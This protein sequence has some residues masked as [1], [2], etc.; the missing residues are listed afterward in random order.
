MSMSENSPV[1]H[2]PMAKQLIEF[3]DSSHDDPG[4]RRWLTDP[5]GLT[6]Y[7]RSSLRPLGPPSEGG[8]RTFIQGVELKTPTDVDCL[9]IADINHPYSTDPV[10]MT[11]F[12]DFIETVYRLKLWDVVCLDNIGDKRI[13]DWCTDHGWTQDDRN[14]PDF[15]YI[16]MPTDQNTVLGI[17]VQEFEPDNQ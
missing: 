4:Q 3:A 14:S 8:L 1:I 16:H 9:E 15:F 5:S 17:N 11:E 7:V 6:V 2:P 13:T 10:D 12:S